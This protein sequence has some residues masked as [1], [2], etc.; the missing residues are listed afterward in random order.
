MGKGEE[1]NES[2]SVFF[3]I[4]K[5]QVGLRLTKL[6]THYFLRRL[7][8]VP[9]TFSKIVDRIAPYNIKTPLVNILENRICLLEN[10]KPKLTYL[11]MGC[12]HILVPQS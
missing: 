6:F 11:D 9:R 1:Q 10:G 4:E 5:V 12:I 2:D 3:H 7:L 8:S